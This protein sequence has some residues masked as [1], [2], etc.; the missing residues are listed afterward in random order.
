M[1]ARRRVAI[2]AMFQSEGIQSPLIADYYEVK[3]GGSEKRA[4]IIG[5]CGM[6]GGMSE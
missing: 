2:L 1:R 6:L 5:E 3:G 4:T